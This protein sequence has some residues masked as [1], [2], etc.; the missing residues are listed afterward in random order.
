MVKVAAIIILGDLRHV[1]GFRP[2]R[3]R[4]STSVRNIFDCHPRTFSQKAYPFISLVLRRAGDSLYV[5]ALARRP[6]P[7]VDLI[8]PEYHDATRK[9]TDLE[10]TLPDV[11]QFRSCTGITR[12]QQEERGDSS[13]VI[14]RG[15]VR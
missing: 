1:L 14:N 13:L 12:N 8:T 3:V 7:C 11:Q 4:V 6:S 9:S 5:V 10:S 15:T 2:K